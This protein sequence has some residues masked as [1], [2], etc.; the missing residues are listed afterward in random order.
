MDEFYPP[1]R[2]EFLEEGQRDPSVGCGCG[3]GR[4]DKHD[5]KHGQDDCCGSD[6]RCEHEERHGFEDRPGVR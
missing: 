3:N 4:G 6:D 2:C 1:E 5:D